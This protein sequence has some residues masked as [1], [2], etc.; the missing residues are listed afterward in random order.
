MIYKNFEEKFKSNLFALISYTIFI[1]A[2]VIFI[3]DNILI[4]HPLK[5]FENIFEITNADIVS[6]TGIKIF[7]THKEYKIYY[8][9]IKKA[10]NNQEKYRLINEFLEKYNSIYI[11]YIDLENTKKISKIKRNKLKDDYIIKEINFDINSLDKI[12][13]VKNAT[14]IKINSLWSEKT[15]EIVLKK[16]K[17]SKLI[18]LDLRGFPF[19][20]E[21]NYLTLYSSFLPSDVKWYRNN[22]G[23][24]VQQKE[25]ILAK[26]KRIHYKNNVILLTDEKTSEISGLFLTEILDNRKE[27]N[28]FTIIYYSK[29]NGN[30]IVYPPLRGIRYYIL[31]NGSILYYPV[32]EFLDSH[33]RKIESIDKGSIINIDKVK[34]LKKLLE[35]Y[36]IY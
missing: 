11:G 13:P 5:V 4:D 20:D 25:F 32:S 33:Y 36:N 24:I 16:I 2:L 6:K 21:K 26:Y 15:L 1:I 14:Y 34:E 31:N 29:N 8:Q 17:E 9:K 12:N 18:I 30:K 22:Y 28:N 27:Y 3:Y 23:D 19:G 10:K 35:E 7:N